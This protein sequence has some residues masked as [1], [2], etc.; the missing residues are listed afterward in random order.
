MDVGRATQQTSGHYGVPASCIVPDDDGCRECCLWFEA[1][2]NGSQFVR[3]AQRALKAPIRVSGGEEEATVAAPGVAASMRKTHGIVGD[4]GGGSLELARLDGMGIDRC[5]SMPL[6]P[7]R[8]MDKG[9]AG[10]KELD[11]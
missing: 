3:E 9:A 8:L 2:Q 11:V 5:I 7:F 10:S 6:G 4:L 1:A